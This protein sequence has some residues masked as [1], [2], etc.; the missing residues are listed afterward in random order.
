MLDKGRYRALWLSTQKLT[1]LR[2][3]A[4]AGCANRLPGLSSDC[5]SNDCNA[6]STHHLLE[7]AS[8]EAL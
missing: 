7:D 3:D 2:N 5:W 1:D 6:R 4:C 8:R